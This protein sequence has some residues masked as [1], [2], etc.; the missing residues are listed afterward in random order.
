MNRFEHPIHDKVYI[1]EDA[2]ENFNE[3]KVIE[4]LKNEHPSDIALLIQYL[5]PSIRQIFINKFYIFITHEVISE[6]SDSVRD[7]V[8][9]DIDP[10]QLADIFKNLENDD[11]IEIFESLDEIQ[12][13]IVLRSISKKDRVILQNTLLFPPK[14]AAR[15]MQNDFP[16][17]RINW[18][19]KQAMNYIKYTDD[20]FDDIGEIFVVDNNQNFIGTVSLHRLIQN[21]LGV[22]ISSIMKK[23][24]ISVD[25]S[26][27]QE[28]VA[29]LFRKY[30]LLCIPVVD[31]ANR[32]IGMITADDILE[33]VEEETKEDYAGMRTIGESDFYAPVF[34][35][36]FSRLR[37]LII[38]ALSSLVSSFVI[39]RYD[40]V[41]SQNVYLSIL[42]NVVAAMGGAYGVQVNT[43]IIRAIA[44]KELIKINYFRTILKEGIIAIING[45][46]FSISLGFISFIWLEDFV[47]SFVL[48]SAIL[49]NI[50]WAGFVGTIFPM[51]LNK[52][53][54]D[55]ALSSG[56]LVAMSTDIVGFIV[57]LSAARLI[58]F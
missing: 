50:I 48:L 35:T 52:I 8:F 58:L 56:P 46:C 1:L 51:I 7:A 23:D 29:N 18:S 13:G 27:D 15:L 53:N 30:S 47:V 44:M 36:S 32:L 20:K 34:N 10:I 5:S 9:S 39:S 2:I 24:V 31:Y 21:D 45:F 28:D 11:A 26:L 40:Y 37:W 22:I 54:L 55:P 41:L 12:Q 6:L 4:I 17:V 33:V 42:L 57:F 14:S 16:A 49:F 43:V 19:V 25:V 3:K 38:T